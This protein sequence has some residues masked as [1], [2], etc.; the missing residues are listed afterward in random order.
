MV[1]HSHLSATVQIRIRD[2]VKQPKLFDGLRASGQ[3]P[4]GGPSQSQ[5]LHHCSRV[6]STTENLLD[7]A[8]QPIVASERIDQEMTRRRC[9]WE[10]W[11]D[12]MLRY[13]DEEWGVPS[14]DERHL[15]EMLVL[16][17]AQAG[18]SWLTILRKRE[19]YRKAFK[20]FDPDAV[21]RFK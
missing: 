8:D 9:D 19:G 1:R 21:A 3:R 16:E 11:D 6:T 2:V 13:H 18:L 5:N 12:L 7:L 20:G 17:C 4:A 14:H 10:P 15:F